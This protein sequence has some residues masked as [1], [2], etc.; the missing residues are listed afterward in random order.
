MSRS[1]IYAF[2][3]LLTHDIGICDP[4]PIDKMMQPPCFVDKEI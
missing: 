3:L 2:V 1:R 4:F